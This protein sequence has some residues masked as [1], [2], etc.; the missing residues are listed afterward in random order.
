MRH[1]APLLRRELSS[2]FL[3]PMAYMVMLAFLLIAMFNFWELVDILSQPQRELSSLR[4]PMNTYISGSPAF[5]LLILVAVPLITMRLF[6]EERR[7]GTIEKL[8]TAPVTETEVVL[9]KWLAGI[10][11]YCVMLIP[12]ALYLPVLY[13]QASFSFD[14]GPVIAVGLGLLTTGMMFVAIGLFMSSLTRNQIIAAIW[15]FLI[16]FGLIVVVPF[17]YQIAAQRQSAFAEGL[18]FVAVLNQI[19]S[20]AMGQLDLRYLFIHLSVCILLLNLTVKV[21]GMRSN[22]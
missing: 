20:L 13:F 9:A 4:D 2:Y 15:T 18:G 16:L 7:S 14:L 21:I 1:V 3:G 22:R 6:A 19:R 17:G 5:W 8:M 10:V 12:F 11:M